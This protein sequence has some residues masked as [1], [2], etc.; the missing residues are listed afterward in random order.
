MDIKTN[1]EKKDVFVVELPYKIGTKLQTFE[2]GKIQHDYVY[3]YIIGSSINVRLMLC[4]DTDPRLSIPIS[5]DHLKKCWK[6]LEKKP[7]EKKS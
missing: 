4:Y 7:K 5:V 1:Q 3:C 2:N 6:P